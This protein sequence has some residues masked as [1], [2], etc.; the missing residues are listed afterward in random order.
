MGTTLDDEEALHY[1][2]YTLHLFLVI[3]HNQ[4]CFQCLRTQSRQRSARLFTCSFTRALDSTYLVPRFATRTCSIGTRPISVAQR[5]VEFPGIL[6]PSIAMIFTKKVTIRCCVLPTSV[7][8]GHTARCL[9]TFCL[10]IDSSTRSRPVRLLPS[11]DTTR[12][13]SNLDAP[14]SPGNHCQ[15]HICGAPN[16]ADRQRSSFRHICLASQ[17]ISGGFD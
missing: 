4:Q 3:H 1:I 5:L 9:C 10:G 14:F 12:S 16:S 13:Y 6:I 15:L 17:A 8:A 2:A 11:S 7:S